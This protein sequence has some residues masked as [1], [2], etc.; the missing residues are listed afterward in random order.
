[1]T[2]QLHESIVDYSDL[3]TDPAPLESLA[4]RSLTR[5]V[6][7]D[8]IDEQRMKQLQGFEDVWAVRLDRL[9]GLLDAQT[10]RRTTRREI[11]KGL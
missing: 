7:P 11:R 2:T 1:M 9:R 5:F 6:R 8:P 10:V 4:I 3:V